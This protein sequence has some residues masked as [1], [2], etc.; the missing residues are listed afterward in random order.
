MTSAETHAAN[1]LKEIRRDVEADSALFGSRLKPVAAMRDAA[2]YSD[3]F[4]DAYGDD[5]EASHTIRL[6]IEY[7]FEGY[8]LHYG[9][10]RLLGPD[11][12]NFHLLAGD[13]MYAR[14]LEAIARLEDL[15]CVEALAELVRLCSYIHCEK[16]DPGLA[17]KAWAVTTLGLAARISS[18]G[19]VPFSGMP[20]F[21]ELEKLDERLEELMAASEGGGDDSGDSGASGGGPV[22]RTASLRERFSKIEADF[23][24]R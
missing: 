23:H 11:D 22:I 8:L 10:S 2:G 18:G 17:A 14:G 3:L 6:G 12:G 9:Q 1:T 15:A 20:A 5:V 4:M 16:L 13:Y 19:A 21:G 7:I 24:G